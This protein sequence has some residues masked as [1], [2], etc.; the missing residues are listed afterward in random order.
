MYKDESIGMR[1][2]EAVAL[3]SVALEGMND[4]EEKGIVRGW[5]AMRELRMS[6]GISNCRREG[7]KG[8]MYIRGDEIVF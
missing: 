3:R 2:E 5:S 7:E 4:E 8:V 1:F 6:G